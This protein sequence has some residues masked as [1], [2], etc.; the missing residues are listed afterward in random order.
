[1][2][3]EP[4]FRVSGA[5]NDFLALVEPPEDP[6]PERIRRWCRRGVSLGADGV[7]VL[8]RTPEGG[9]L[10]HW[11]SDG[12]R[13]ALCLN[14]S[15]CAGRL[16]FEVG[17]AE[18]SESVL[19]TDSGELGVRLAGD[20]RVTV[21]LPFPVLEPEPLALVLGDARYSGFRVMVG[22]PHFVL[23][24]L[25]SLDGLPIAELG[26]ALR[27]HPRL[28]EPGANVDFV[29]FTG[30]TRFEV[31]TWE[32]GVEGETLACGSGVVAV[33]AVGVST[34]RLTLPC[35]GRTASGY[36]LDVGGDDLA[37]LTLTGDA[38]ILAHGEMRSSAAEVPEPATWT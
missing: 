21:R 19:A 5:G 3:S 18:G 37:R 35:G 32:R 15:R 30:S 25:Q 7:L 24:V 11:N 20:D 26:P 10:V 38:R 29:R 28:G 36:R 9:Q 27:A 8:R 13:S 34:G 14:G 16:L 23:P 22:V 4:F 31:R 17:W 2:T 12:T 1:M 33:A 6:G